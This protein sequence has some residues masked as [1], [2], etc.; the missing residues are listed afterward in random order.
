MLINQLHWDISTQKQ[1]VTFHGI[2]KLK[3]KPS[4]LFFV[5]RHLL[6]LSLISIFSSTVLLL[7]DNHLETET[8]RQI[9]ND[10]FR[11]NT[12]CSWL[13]STSNHPPTFA[14]VVRKQ[15]GRRNRSIDLSDVRDSNCFIYANH[16]IDDG[17]V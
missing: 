1:L 2:I 10:S 7:T 5:T 15:I 4:N 12:R 16:T 14:R 13:V 9:A 6:Q 8:N 11:Y 17:L 3:I